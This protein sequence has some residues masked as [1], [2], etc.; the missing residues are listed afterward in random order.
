M[1]HK[2]VASI[3]LTCGCFISCD[4]ASHLVLSYTCYITCRV[5]RTSDYAS[6]TI[7]CLHLHPL[8]PNSN[9][10]SMSTLLINEKTDQV[11]MAIS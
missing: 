8:C 4:K 3:K 2:D 5:A 7:F 9:I 11:F 1:W 6:T 10:F